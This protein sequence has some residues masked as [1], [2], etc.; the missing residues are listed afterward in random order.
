MTER[1][2]GTEKT[3]GQRP[4]VWMAI[5]IAG[6]AA[7]FFA[8]RATAPGNAQAPVVPTPPNLNIAPINAP[9]P[10]N[11]A[12]DPMTEGLDAL[13]KQKDPVKAAARF[14]EVLAAD[15]S[16]Y[17][18][19]YQLATALE[20][21]GDRVGARAMWLKMVP[22]AE[23]NRDEATLAKANARIAALKE[24]AETVT[25]ADPLGE[26]MRLGLGALYEKKDALGAAKYFREVLAKNPTHYGATYQLAT[27][28]EQA[29][30]SEE[31][32]PYWSKTLEMAE[33]NKD[34]KTAEIA[35]KHLGKAAIFGGFQ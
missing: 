25:D 23:A 31:A 8:G 19:T 27:A 11:A 14:R 9:L 35:R 4:T 1:S 12:R 18:A 28:L 10:G 34:T 16:H 2:E 5:G 30:K 33:A 26:T 20:Q 13:Y 29:G 21:A 32:K 17:G 22:M 3:S 6:L 15:P 24:P 7:A